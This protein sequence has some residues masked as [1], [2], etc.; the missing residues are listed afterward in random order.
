MARQHTFVN[1][2]QNNKVV[3]P[4]LHASTAYT[5]MVPLVTS[6]TFNDRT[7]L[8]DAITP[9]P[10]DDRDVLRTH[11]ETR[12]LNSNPVDVK[13]TLTSGVLN[14]IQ[15]SSS[16]SAS[17]PTDTPVVSVSTADKNVAEANPEKSSATESSEADV[18]IRIN[19]TGMKGSNLESVRDKVVK[20]NPRIQVDD[21]K[22]LQH[23]PLSEESET[24]SG[25]LHKTGNNCPRAT[26]VG[27]VEKDNGFPSL[28]ND[29]LALTP[30]EARVETMESQCNSSIE[31]QVQD[32]SNDVAA[33]VSM[34]SLNVP[35][36]TPERLVV[37]HITEISGPMVPQPSATKN[38]KRRKAPGPSKRISK[39]SNGNQVTT[40]G[41]HVCPFPNCEKSF[42]KKFNL[43]AHMRLHTGVEPYL[44]SFPMCGKTFK[45][46]SS[47]SF[48]EKL[49]LKTD[50]RGNQ[51]SQPLSKLNHSIVV[52]SNPHP[53]SRPSPSAL[54]SSDTGPYV[55][56]PSPVSA[57]D[58]AHPILSAPTPVS[59]GA[60]SSFN[61]NQIPSFAEP[62]TGAFVGL[63]AQTPSPPTPVSQGAA[64]APPG[65]TSSDVN[66]YNAEL[67]YPSLVARMGP[68]ERDM[69]TSDHEMGLSSSVGPT[70]RQTGNEP[71]QLSSGLEKQ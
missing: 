34:A 40:P 6:I 71:H 61:A 23:A 65:S 32:R 70:R 56:G 15:A 46:K 7:A 27:T 33:P 31:G 49:H 59:T 24:T 58:I 41:Q 2:R 42:G 45:W 25:T 43:K 62:F 11:S 48:H 16:G 57:A 10:P 66:V 44:C 53:S 69:E 52:S 8:T 68:Q 3:L 1:Q 64:G 63:G 30:S 12:R 37:L 51:G 50:D 47:L 38:R 9:T 28:S 20:T 36:V 54:N 22:I 19:A 26:N 4:H 14:T 35:A 13:T 55:Y 67:S 39:P 60:G 21:S 5:E 17:P 18:P 29:R